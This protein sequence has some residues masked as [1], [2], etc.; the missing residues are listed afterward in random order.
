FMGGPYVSY[1][2]YNKPKGELIFIDT[3]VYAPGEDKRDLVQKLDCIVK[4]LS[5]PS[6]GGK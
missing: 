1:A 3:F 2:V 6:L 4:T 5:L